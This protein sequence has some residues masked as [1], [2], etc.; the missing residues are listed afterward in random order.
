MRMHKKLASV[1][2][3]PYPPSGGTIA[4]SS[5]TFSSSVCLVHFLVLSEFILTSNANQ[6]KTGSK[7][8]LYYGVGLFAV[9][10]IL[11]R[12]SREQLNSM[13]GWFVK[14]KNSCNFILIFGVVLFCFVSFRFVS[15]SLFLLFFTLFSPSEPWRNLFLF[16]P[17]RKDIGT[18]P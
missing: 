16:Y 8:L 6:Y 3:H 9:A 1:T 2:T 10:E 14:K 18:C 12:F 15:L 4:Q 7:M 13:H 11:I 17:T 5:V